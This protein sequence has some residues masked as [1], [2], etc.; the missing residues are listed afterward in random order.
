MT[1][2]LASFLDMHQRGMAD[3]AEQ[4]GEA[5]HYAMVPQLQRH[6]VAE[7]N[8]THGDRQLTG[9]VKFASWNVFNLSGTKKIKKRSMA[10]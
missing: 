9:V 1:A 8:S 3:V 4:V 10:K 7:E 6:K 5:A 2:H